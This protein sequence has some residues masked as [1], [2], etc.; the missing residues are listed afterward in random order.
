MI[1]DST[2]YMLL[3]ILE[4]NPKLSQ[5]ELA[6]EIGFSL[7]KTNYCIKALIDKGWIKVR[8][9]RNSRS[10]R[11]YLYVLTPSG[12][13]E[14]ARVTRSFLAQKISDFWST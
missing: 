2:R 3:R 9:F 4:K 11:A 13:G 5:R 6:D 1:D 8:S 10:K 12:I 7:G 14:K